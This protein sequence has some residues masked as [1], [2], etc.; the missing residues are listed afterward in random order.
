MKKRNVCRNPHEINFW[1]WPHALKYYKIN[2]IIKI[3]ISVYSN[4]ESTVLKWHSIQ[5][6]EV[7]RFQVFYAYCIIS[8]AYLWPQMAV[9]I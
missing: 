4:S 6:A 3:Q 1:F 5:S 2:E 9:T 7:K 8:I